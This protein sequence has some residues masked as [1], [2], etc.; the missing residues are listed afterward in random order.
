M[1]FNKVIFFSR[2][3]DVVTLIHLVLDKFYLIV[4]RQYNSLPFYGM[5]VETQITEAV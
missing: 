5:V 1:V 4:P 3:F 2:I